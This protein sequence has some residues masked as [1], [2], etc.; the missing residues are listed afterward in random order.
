MTDGF[1]PRERH[2]IALVVTCAVIVTGLVAVLLGEEVLAFFSI[3][4][5]SLR[6][7]GGIIILGIALAMMRDD[8]PSAGDVKAVA[9]GSQRRSGIGVVPLAIPLT[10][11]PGAISTAIIFAHQLNDSAEVATLG[12][13]VFA[14]GAILGLSLLFAAP[15]ARA[16]GPTGIS[17]VSRIMAIILAAVAI[18]MIFSGAFDALEHRYPNLPALLTP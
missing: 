13:T 7:A 14:V 6:I 8:P 1:S 11:G 18:E 2:R 17:V 16:V 5:P 3:G 4:V 10:F 9:A 15:I 12:L